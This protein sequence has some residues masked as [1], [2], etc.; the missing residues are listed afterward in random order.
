[1]NIDRAIHRFFRRQVGYLFIAPALIMLFFITIY[2]VVRTI[3]LSIANYDLQT[4]K[5]SWAGFTHYV[6]AFKDS[7][8]WV[9][10][11]N[12][13]LFTV[14]TVVLHAVIAW[15][16]ALLMQNPWRWN[17]LRN[18]IRGFWIL[19]WLFSNAA[20]ALMWGLLYHP[21]G[22]LNYLVLN[23]GLF[24][25]TID[26]LGDPKIALWSLVIVN[27]WKSYPIYFVL[28]LGAFQAIPYDLMEAARVEGAN[29]F[30]EL[31]Y[32]ILPLVLPAVLTMTMLDFITTFAHFDLVRMMTGGGPMRA[33]ET[34]SYYIYRIGFKS[35][36]FP[37]SS[38][39]SVI[40]F[41]FLAI[42]SLVY[43]RAYIRSTVY[44]R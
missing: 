33:T 17:W 27:V 42:C 31:R 19:P 37:Y 4:F 16:L 41:V 12:T 38:S 34:L 13:L 32:V 44:G 22:L 29:F 3:H 36:D 20:A 9:S 1:M 15:I 40:M 43:V 2:P 7:W 8:F 39:L 14:R 23:S 18:G 30:Q 11:K 35:V 24:K 5:L 21:F 28:L 6:R 10:I 25:D 26:F